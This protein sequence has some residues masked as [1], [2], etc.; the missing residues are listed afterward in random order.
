MDAKKFG[1]FVAQVRREQDMTQKQLAKKLNVTDK[2]VS[3][4]ERGLGFPD[5]SLLEPLADTLGLTIAELMKSERIPQEEIPQKEV[6][7]LL[8]E[9]FVLMGNQWEE[10]WETRRNIS[11][12]FIFF[13]S[14]LTL[15]I[16]LPLFW[17]LGIYADEA[18]TS[19]AAVL[20]G[21]FWLCMDWGLLGI[22][23]VLAVVSVFSLFSRKKGPL[24][25][26]L[27]A[28]AGAMFISIG[29]LR[30]TLRYVERVGTTLAAVAG[31][32]LW[33]AMEWARIP[34][35]LAA[36]VLADAGLQVWDQKRRRLKTAMRI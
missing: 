6:S 34:L 2:A 22:L 18:G 1:A 7:D 33:A 35:L 10:K 8:Q 26:A 16:S 4:W 23:G 3:R 12:F 21:D 20:G 31:G 15:L 30:N 9:A 36:T 11:M 19:P 13:L 32:E 17:N 29:L 25:F 28:S 24:F 5:I 27:F 14:V